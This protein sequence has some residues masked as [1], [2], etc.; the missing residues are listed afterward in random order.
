MEMRRATLVHVDAMVR[1]SESFRD[2]LATLSPVFWRKAPDPVERQTVFFR[3]L[4][5]ANDALAFVA[6]R[7]SEVQGFAIGRLTTAPPVYAP[8]GP[9]C[10]V[11]DFCISPSC[12]W[13]PVGAL[14]LEAIEAVALERGAV[15][16]VVVCPRL[17]IAK[18][19]FLA[20]QGFEPTSEWHVRALRAAV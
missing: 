13:L 17:S 20:A 12:P 16:S 15:L 6:E 10:L 14:F 5:S 9:V 3:A 11:D 4:L 1:L 19:E 2:H 18:R 8:P 7:D